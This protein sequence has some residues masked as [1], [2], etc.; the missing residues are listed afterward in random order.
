MRSLMNEPHEVVYFTDRDLGP[1]FRQDCE[2]PD[3][4]SSGTMTTSTN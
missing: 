2:P 4:W 1:G 3:C